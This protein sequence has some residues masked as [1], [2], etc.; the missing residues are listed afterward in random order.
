MSLM[1]PPDLNW[2]FYVIA[3]QA[4]PE[5]DEDAVRL[6]ASEWDQAAA[7]LEGASG[8]YSQLAGRVGD[9]VGGTV[10]NNFI[11]FAG[12]LGRSGASFATSARQIAAA[13]RD[14]ALNIEHAKYNI[15]IQ[16]SVVAA[17]ILWAA[18]DPFTAPLIPGIWAAGRDAVMEIEGSLAERLATLATELAKA[19]AFEASEEVAEEMLA[20]I[21]Q[22]GQGNRDGLDIPQLL[23]NAALGAIGG[24]FAHGALGALGRADR[25]FHTQ[26]TPTVYASAGVQGATQLVVGI[27]GAVLF[28][29]DLDD[30]GWSVVSGALTGAAIHSG[31]RAGNHFR[32]KDNSSGGP[33]S[34]P[35]GPNTVG[36][37]DTKITTNPITVG[38]SG[39]TGTGHDQ[40]GN[41]NQSGNGRTGD[42]PAENEDREGPAPQGDQP[43]HT[44][45]DT[46]DPAQHSGPA[47][48]RSDSTT[49]GL[50]G[51]DDG[52]RSTHPDQ[53]QPPTGSGPALLNP[54]HP[55][56]R[57]GPA[58]VESNHPAAT[59][60]NHPAS[61][62]GPV[63]TEPNRSAA[64]D[65]NGPGARPD[66]A[67]TD[68]NHPA[69][70]SGPAV[71]EPNHPAATD[72]QHAGS[73]PGPADTNRPASRSGPADS[74]RPASQTGPADPTRSASQTGPSAANRPAAQQGPAGGQSSSA[75]VTAKNPTP[76]PKIGHLP[77]PAPKIGWAEQFPVLD[78]NLAGGAAH[79][80]TVVGSNNH[81]LDHHQALTAP[82]GTSLS[83]ESFRSPRDGNAYYTEVFHHLRAV[84]P[85]IDLDTC[86]QVVV[87]ASFSIA[88]GDVYLSG[89]GGKI[90]LGHAKELTGEPFRRATADDIVTHM[91]NQPRGAMGVVFH[92]GDGTTGHF[93]LAYKDQRGV[94]NFV[95]VKHSSMDALHS[96]D[97]TGFMP[98]PW[99]GARPLGSSDVVLRAESTG[100]AGGHGGLTFR[101]NKEIIQK[102]TNE[103]EVQTY[104]ELR[105]G[106]PDAI[107]EVVPPSY[108]VEQVEQRE[109][110]YGLVPPPRADGPE[111][112][113]D[114]ITATMD[115]V[116]LLDI[117]IG[118]RTAS[119]EEL[120]Q[121]GMS[122]ADARKKKFKLKISDFVTG[123]DRRGYRVV[124]MTGLAESRLQAGRHSE[125]HIQDF[126]PQDSPE[127]WHAHHDKI[128]QEL[129]GV[130]AA[131]EKSD[132]A[133]IAGSVLIAVGKD[134]VTGEP[135]TKVSF[136]DLAHPVKKADGPSFAKY[137]KNLVDGM[138]NLIEEFQHLRPAANT[139]LGEGAF[140]FIGDPE[141]AERLR[142]AVVSSF[143]KYGATKEEVAN[144]LAD[145]AR[146]E[147]A[148]NKITSPTERANTDQAADLVVQ[149]LV[150]GQRGLRGG[151]PDTTV[152][153][154]LRMYRDPG[155]RSGDVGVMAS[156]QRGDGFGDARSLTEFVDPN[157]GM[158]RLGDRMGPM[159]QFVE[160]WA[161]RLHTDFNSVE[162][163]LLVSVANP[164]ARTVA[165]VRTII[166]DAIQR[167]SAAHAGPGSSTV[168]EVM[169]NFVRFSPYRDSGSRTAVLLDVMKPGS[170][171]EI[172]RALRTGMTGEFRVH[173]G[174]KSE[175]FDEDARA[176]GEIGRLLGNWLA[177]APANAL[178]PDVRISA[179]V[180]LRLNRGSGGVPHAVLERQGKGE[181]L[182][183]LRDSVSIDRDDFDR[184]PITW[185]LD[186]KSDNNVRARV[187]ADADRTVDRIRDAHDLT[188]NY[189]PNS[190]SR[191]PAAT[192]RDLKL[193]LGGFVARFLEGQGA[194][195]I[196]LHLGVATK[197]P[198][199]QDRIDDLTSLVRNE[200]AKAWDALRESYGPPAFSALPTRA[201]ED[202]I[203]RVQ[204]EPDPNLP[205]GV[206]LTWSPPA[207]VE[208]SEPHHEV[209]GESAIERFPD[210][211]AAMDAAAELLGQGDHSRAQSLLRDVRGSSP[212]DLDSPGGHQ[213]FD[214]DLYSATPRSESPEPD[215]VVRRFLDDPDA[216]R[217]A[218]DLLGR[219][220]DELAALAQSF[221]PLPA[222]VDPLNRFISAEVMA[223]GTEFVPGTDGVH[224]FP[225]YLDGLGV[226]PPNALRPGL[227]VG[228]AA[229]GEL[230][231]RELSMSWARR[232]MLRRN[233]DGSY[234]Y[235][236]DQVKDA[237]GRLEIK[238]DT[239][240]RWRRA[241]EAELRAGPPPAAA[242]PS[243][244]Q[245]DEL[246]GFRPD[247][248]G[249][250]AERVRDLGF[251][252][253]IDRKASWVKDL[254]W[255]WIM[256]YDRERIQGGRYPLGDLA[257]GEAI[258]RV[259]GE[260]AA[261]FSRNNVHDLRH[262]ATA[263]TA[264]PEPS[265]DLRERFVTADPRGEPSSWTALKLVDELKA[266]LVRRG[267]F[268]GPVF[269]VDGDPQI[270]AKY[271][272]KW[273]WEWIEALARNLR[274]RYP[275]RGRDT[276]A[277][278]LGGLA[279]TKTVWEWVGGIVRRPAD[280]S[281]PIDAGYGY[282]EIDLNEIDFDDL[283]DPGVRFDGPAGTVEDPMPLSDLVSHND[284]GVRSFPGGAYFVGTDAETEIVTDA[285]HNGLG[286][287]DAFTVAVHH[288]SEGFLVRGQRVDTAGLGRALSA[289][290][291][292][293]SQRPRVVLLSCDVAVGDRL[294]ELAAVL[295]G[296]GYEGEVIGPDGP[297]EVFSNGRIRLPEGGS[298]IAIG[299]D[300]GRRAVDLP[301]LRR[302]TSGPPVRSVVMSPDGDRAA[303]RLRTNDGHDATPPHGD[304]PQP[305]YVFAKPED[306][307]AGLATRVSGDAAYRQ[308]LSQD[309]NTPVAVVGL[310]ESSR[311]FAEAL[312][313]NGS[314]REVL[315]VNAQGQF[316]R[317]SRLRPG[318]A[319]TVELVDAA[320]KTYGVGF[321]GSEGT[322]QAW[323][324]NA[325]WATVHSRRLIAERD[326]DGSV[327]SEAEEDKGVE[328]VAGWAGTTEDGRAESLHVML[329]SAGGSHVVMLDDS[330][331]QL[332][333]SNEEMAGLLLATDVFTTAQQGPVRPGVVIATD[334][335]SAGHDPNPGL[336]NAMRRLAGPQHGFSYTGTVS[337]GSHGELEVRP[338][339]HFTQY[340]L[341]LND[342]RHVS[343]GSTFGFPARPADLAR[344]Q[345][346]AGAV[347]AGRVRD[348]A[349]GD[350]KPIFVSVDGDTGHANLRLTSGQLSEQDGGQVARL[351]L[352]NP[353]FK[354]Q[355]DQ[356]PGRPIVL[357]AKNGAAR[358]N[359]GGF[360]FDFAG[361]LREEG[362]FRDIYAPPAEIGRGFESVSG[363]RSGDLKTTVLLS[364]DG[365]TAVQVVRSPGDDNF[366]AYLRGWVNHA[367]L[368]GFH[369]EPPV[370][371]VGRST[372]DGFAAIRRDGNMATLTNEELAHVL[373]DD[374]QL[375]TL[376]GTSPERPLMLIGVGT[377]IDGI[378][379]FA[380]AMAPGG[381]SR[382]MHMPI[383]NVAF[384]QSGALVLA[385]GLR[386]AEPI[387]PTPN[388]FA[389][390]PHVSQ[391][392][393]V[394]G[395]FFP[396]RAFDILSDALN[397]MRYVG[398]AQQTYHREVPG[399]T[400][401]ENSPW[402]GQDP[403][404]VDGH[405]VGLHGLNFAL[406]TGRPHVRGD[407]LTLT[408]PQ[409]ARAI[410]GSEIFRAAG[411]G[412]LVVLGHC[413]SNRSAPGQ[414]SVAYYIKRA[415]ENDFRPV[416][417]WGADREVLLSSEG[418]R[419]VL[420]GGW[421]AEV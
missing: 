316:E 312:R 108:E 1:V 383:G 49:G 13:L 75:E 282:P 334:E 160:G 260:N 296:A 74:N 139:V 208:T 29:G 318:D 111:V 174:Q 353:G 359:F 134:R 155:L 320:G 89:P 237:S 12:P 124:D 113:I 409:A 285:F 210:D 295:H 19:A 24:I 389:G 391:D 246:I 394:H 370:L 321:P 322:E 290:E 417:I 164:N 103:P 84:D 6:L 197:S 380:Q 392:G 144:H 373:R 33:Q 402:A 332:P 167:A 72:T 118:R 374:R 150:D 341:S 418:E 57:S 204:I 411:G 410:Y 148:Y 30:L 291:Q 86:F 311:E 201:Q 182:R 243:R 147:A 363:W 331:R 98:L 88:E 361:A 104:S 308:A 199:T 379:G 238:R 42:G 73:Q 258:G 97:T 330:E 32:P 181:I 372:V 156:G 400:V 70:Q 413:E 215:S 378:D 87:Q 232:M 236:A 119:K 152:D 162:D 415:W 277:I 64:T 412:D 133:F 366:V 196:R 205:R 347:D 142:G 355:L 207:E 280:D 337:Q 165:G 362:Y 325:S 77:T 31:F 146:V 310:G 66:G 9:N 166:H 8:G 302:P 61:Q 255:E 93:T 323:E 123:S 22:I 69:S 96:G 293:W 54:N 127:V 178:P 342:V 15:L 420:D 367:K 107:S 203:G 173:D 343:H 252:D 313:G 192:E 141:P 45:K 76:E 263:W 81:G 219:G 102:P 157:G 43:G 20:Q 90:T 180:G 248:G 396:S 112:F 26:F 251:S 116:K 345:Q 278:M 249:T 130:L 326:D 39:H 10:G 55:A 257:M 421:F 333:V 253:A 149:H 216:M 339:E 401:E 385:G 377:P 224:T 350:R 172:E 241:A 398:D 209:P 154:L 273:E 63:A 40:T 229:L 158:A 114:N 304:G 416:T 194:A 239:L 59:D 365:T 299:P 5:G 335:P 227:F 200:V 67:T 71:V 129:D 371:V 244:E 14:Y 214:D 284:S 352:K 329:E 121:H 223:N 264:A 230:G 382:T 403:W 317:V 211:P 159:A 184:L 231:R 185:S 259:S 206:R 188:L 309:P 170:L 356:D 56:S 336:L 217:A 80:E 95:D 7:L 100:G 397:G 340:P 269:V 404:L 137:H 228:P 34:G 283:G 297:V 193:A 110:D 250:L 202:L 406:I 303:K 281:A 266:E 245:W 292:E 384:D 319:R 135:S 189:T 79:H 3:G 226:L 376:M 349:W 405:G 78:P 358:N 357:L 169:D 136:I 386:T 414:F 218:Q 120:V 53:T 294:D 354:E 171:G 327:S 234:R 177:L 328:T 140:D 268:H 395:Q 262:V 117:K 36:G 85:D 186:H 4:W 138:K 279:S 163:K 105:G 240:G 298:F 305:F 191:F 128:V 176:L 360:G 271:R 183:L 175:L 288:N 419:T 198:Y 388:D 47:T 51:F 92:A 126:I 11:D 220:D 35:H 25:K 348:D 41:G 274:A 106:N 254:T 221:R 270:I 122:E 62:S 225:E 213:G 83:S 132:Y 233:D 375:R 48:G 289:L 2:V 27:T 265:A 91:E 50:P 300:G 101:A 393:V 44:A 58:A 261:A 314:Y 338:G 125:T 46:P 242:R 65:P 18:L 301:G 82:D 94:T 276:I 286:D 52:A 60:L 235:T 306:D 68:P 387:M 28:G 272:P 307:A 179:E 364:N 351:L 38:S 324:S 161:R 187:F 17:N 315:A 109:R 390:Y 368:E 407:V 346:L 195:D 99:T 23:Q 151:A 131:A 115:D 408:G 247:D 344:L 143:Q 16:I 267:E 275:E 153:S 222:P 212:M 145:G 21:I 381:Y 190:R 399:D 256:R 287:P 168:D 369:D 37:L